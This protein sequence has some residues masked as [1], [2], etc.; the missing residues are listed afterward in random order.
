MTTLVLRIGALVALTAAAPAYSQSLADLARQEE[1]RRATSKSVMSWSNSDLKPG[2]VASSATPVSTGA[3]DPAGCYMSV[4]LARCIS[5]SEMLAQIKKA[6]QVKFESTWRSRAGRIR[7]L[8]A[9]LQTDIDAYTRIVADGR[10]VESERNAAARKLVATVSAMRDQESQWQALEQEA[11]A[12]E[13]PH[14]LLEPVPTFPNTQ[15]Q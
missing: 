5:A 2:E 1:A 6:E 8:V 15:P 11:A 13:M 9:R 7:A 3:V 14:S 12:A 10:R 4:S